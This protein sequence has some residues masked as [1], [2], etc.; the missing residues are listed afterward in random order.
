MVDNLVQVIR[1]ADK[2]AASRQ[3]LGL[4]PRVTRS[5]DKADMR[6]VPAY[7]FGQFHPVHVAWHADI[8]KDD[9]DA[10]RFVFENI[11]G[12][13]GGAGF[14][15]HEIG[16][17]ERVFRGHADESFIIHDNDDAQIR[18]G[19]HGKETTAVNAGSSSRDRKCLKGHCDVRDGACYFILCRI[20]GDRRRCDRTLRAWLFGDARS[21][22]GS[23]LTATRMIACG[24]NP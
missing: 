23:R 2:A 20:L 13:L 12:F 14:H 8:R 24:S 5:S 9:M 3:A 11:D 18:M 17:L 10:G 7:V 4:Q 1:L 22:M 16:I 6:P 19:A 15:G 21:R